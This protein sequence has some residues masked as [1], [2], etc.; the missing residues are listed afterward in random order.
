MMIEK[1]SGQKLNSYFRENIFEPLGI[2]ATLFPDHEMREHVVKMH[3][4]LEDGT[5]QEREHWFQK[6]LQ[7]TEDE[8]PSLFHNGGGGGWSTAADYCGSFSFRPTI[9]SA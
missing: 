4:R 9:M 5:L 3:Q 6:S 7:V 8:I 2:S 1:A